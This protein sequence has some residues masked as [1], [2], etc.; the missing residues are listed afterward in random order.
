M[1]GAVNAVSVL[2]AAL[3]PA[4]VRRLPPGAR[5]R[6]QLL[7]NRA[8]KRR[9]RT[10]RAAPTVH[11]FSVDGSTSD[12]IQRY[13]YVFGTWEPQ[14]TD[15]VRDHLRPGDVVV[16]VGANIGYFS[17]LASGLVGHTG[18]VIAFEAVPSIADALER[19]LQRN[20]ASVEVHRRAVG[21]S[22]G[23]IE[24]FRSIGSNVGRSGTS[25]GTDMLSE[26]E[27]PVVRGADALPRELWSR[28]RLVKI[29]VEGDEQRVLRGLQPVLAALPAGA[30]VL[31]EVTPADLEERG[32]SAEQVMTF[33]R[34]LG[35]DALAIENSYAA[36]DYAHHERRPPQPLMGVPDR[37]TDVIFVKRS[38]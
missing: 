2:V 7:M 23:A 17:L 1:S 19:N 16:D 25:G 37:Q 18:S 35:F 21:E 33:M 28:I 8:L 13:L 30:A 38:S 4:R 5:A 22:P 24:V 14:L 36:A 15:W 10:F 11:G 32:G 29:D 12:L 20:G 31:T 34:D 6:V 26:G 27:V 9:P 3:P